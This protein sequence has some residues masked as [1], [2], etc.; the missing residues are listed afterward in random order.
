MISLN[1]NSL[2][3]HSVKDLAGFVPC[4][5]DMDYLNAL[6]VKV[7]PSQET[8]DGLVRSSRIFQQRLG[9]GKI[10]P[11][12]TV[13]RKRNRSEQQTGKPQYYREMPCAYLRDPEIFWFLF[14]FRVWDSNQCSENLPYFLDCFKG[15]NRFLFFKGDM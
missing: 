10:I 5:V 3:E 2:N 4:I 14:D 6:G 15:P 11:L 13:E 8:L 7:M 9:H 1:N 12:P